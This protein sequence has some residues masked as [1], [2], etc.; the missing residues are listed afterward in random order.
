[1]QRRLRPGAPPARPRQH[2][3]GAVTALGE[4]L[5]GGQRWRRRR[6]GQRSRRRCRLSLPPATLSLTG[7]RRRRRR[8]RSRLSCR[9]VHDQVCTGLHC[10]HRLLGRAASRQGGTALRVWDVSILIGRFHAWLC[11]R[12]SLGHV[13]MFRHCS[14]RSGVIQWE[15]VEAAGGFGRGDDGRRARHLR[16]EGAGRL[17]HRLR[18]RTRRR[19]LRRRRVVQPILLPMNHTPPLTHPL[20]HL[21]LPHLPH[22][23][24]RLP[25]RRDR[26]QRRQRQPKREHRRENSRRQPRRTPLRQRRGGGGE[27]VVVVDD[28]A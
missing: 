22:P 24:R 3:S 5:S 27:D 17:L 18:R 21:P 4:G 12:L 20:P 9:L 14:G 2:R 23:P 26:R 13:C 16:E 1:M 15:G 6:V 8:C 25:H 19:R 10:A 11:R 7:R 28:H